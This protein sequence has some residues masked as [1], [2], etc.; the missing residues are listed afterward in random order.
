MKKLF[1]LL[2][3]FVMLFSF[4]GCKKDTIDAN[5]TDAF[6][7][8][9]DKSLDDIASIWQYNE[10]IGFD[11]TYT[12]VVEGAMLGFGDAQITGFSDGV[13][14]RPGDSTI[15]FIGYIFTLAQDTDK[16]EF[17]QMLKDNADLN[18]NGVN[19]A[20][21]VVVESDSDKVIV[22]ITPESYDKPDTTNETTLPTE[23][24]VPVYGDEFVD[25]F[26]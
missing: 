14:L 23:D 25:T 18:F 22:I 16:K 21:K 8:N 24:E 17:M 10:S 7:T 13:M 20:D 26:E 9:S 1:A 12:H 2:L 6:K 4:A 15:P 5:L 19:S 11:T 3:V